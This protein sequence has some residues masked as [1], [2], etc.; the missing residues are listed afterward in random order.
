ML[1]KAD[2]DKSSS[3]SPPCPSNV[4][5]IAVLW[6]RALSGRVET[7]D[8][9]SDRLVAD[10]VSHCIELR[11]ELRS[12]RSGRNAQA[13]YVNFRRHKHGRVALPHYDDFAPKVTRGPNR[14]SDVN[15]AVS[16]RGQVRQPERL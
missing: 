8:R 11:R 1:R 4:G 3:D 16:L 9:M 7:G 10:D 15:T 14:P 2:A 12:S 13:S 6:K 5:L